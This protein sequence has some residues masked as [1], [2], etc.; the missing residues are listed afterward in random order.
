MDS[1]QLRAQLGSCRFSDLRW[2][3]ETGSTNEDVLALARAGEPEGIVVVADHQSAG[4]GRLGRS[5]EAPAGSSLLVSILCRPDL[6]PADAHLVTSA[7]GVAAVEAVRQVTGVVVRLKW[8]N[9]VVVERERATRKLGGILAESL[10]DGGRLGAVV[11]GIGINVNWPSEFPDELASIATALNHLTGV[12][13]DRELLLVRFLQGFGHWYDQLGAPG[14][15]AELVTR[16]REECQTLDHEVRVELAGESFSGRAV[17]LTEEGH[18]LV[19]P[20]GATDPR[21]IVAGDVV[22]LRQR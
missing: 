5:W 20:D 14:G 17:G 11:V 15:R 18:L 4:R 16:Y 19:V 3:P 9:D 21:I 10:L 8:P 13:V 7:A 12:P 6:A 1:E 22:H 2:V